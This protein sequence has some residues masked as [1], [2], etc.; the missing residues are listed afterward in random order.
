MPYCPPLPGQRARLATGLTLTLSRPQ[1][2]K[3][4]ERAL[5]WIWLVSQV[6]LFAP[7]F[8]VG[9]MAEQVTGIWCAPRGGVRS[10]S[11]GLSDWHGLPLCSA[12]SAVGSA[13][14]HCR[15]VCCLAGAKR[16]AS[17]GRAPLGRALGAAAALSM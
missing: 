12:C 16:V 8:K 11:T 17:A 6:V 13:G 5:L 1:I 14:E 4:W 9:A 7:N 10:G 2:P 15:A 3:F